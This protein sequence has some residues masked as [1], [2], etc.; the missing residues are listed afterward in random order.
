MAKVTGPLFSFNASGSLGK[1]IVY[2]NW[3]GVAY[4]RELVIPG[5]SRT[6]Q[7]GKIRDLIKDASQGWLTG[8]TDGTTTIDA[9]YK[10]VYDAAALGRPLSGFNMFIRDCVGKNY[11]GSV[12][13]YY[14]ETI[15][16]PTTP[17][18]STP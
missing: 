18:D 17:G 1:A 7:Q 16:Y 8:D 12:S 13:P 10:A 11:D 5:F 9:T 14:D 15:V 6:F 3:R 4:V 2:S